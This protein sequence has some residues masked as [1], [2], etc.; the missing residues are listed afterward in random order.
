VSNYLVD[1]SIYALPECI[2][3][4]PNEEIVKSY[5]KYI[6]NFNIL[7]NLLFP[8]GET[9]INTFLKVNQF[10][11]S[12]SDLKILNN[13]NLALN[14]PNK[15]KLEIILRKSKQKYMI[16]GLWSCYSNIINYLYTQDKNY[17][18][19][20]NNIYLQSPKPKRWRIL[21]DYL[22]IDNIEVKVNNIC[23]TDITK[24]IK[25]VSLSENLK[26]NIC[27]LAFLNHCV[28]KT[29]DITTIIT[30][31][32]ENEF[33]LD[34]NV[35]NVRHNFNNIQNRIWISKGFV[36]NIHIRNIKSYNFLSLRQVIEN[37]ESKK[38][39]DNT[40]IFSKTINDSIDEYEGILFRLFEASGNETKN[41][42]EY[43]RTEYSNIVFD[44]LDGLNKLV[45]FIKTNS[46][47][48]PFQVISQDFSECEKW[49]RDNE[50]CKKCCC[51]L[52]LCGY[53]CSG[54]NTKRKIGDDS[55]VIH[56]K[57]Y[58]YN[59]EGKEKHLINLTLRIYFRWDDDKIQVGYIGKHLP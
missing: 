11:F 31:S 36:K 20:Q 37:I 40:L 26:K 44:C 7:I 9:P 2:P 52:K 4:N 5:E 50:I 18:S 22:D 3:E 19:E 49:I 27:M 15:G 10:L 17:T 47:L 23:N 46:I 38:L 13:Q 28:Y 21:E 29:S 57:P 48:P 1:A 54:E 39:F 59:T 58:S 8:Y 12:S 33:Q 53:N 43:Y 34:V 6:D 42:I 41:D 30:T 14:R 35:E 56:L 16:H 32:S 45:K 24:D 25:S 51:Y 55:Y